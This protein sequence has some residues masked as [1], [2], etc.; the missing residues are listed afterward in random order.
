V[1]ALD[2]RAFEQRLDAYGVERS[3]EA[4]AVRVR[5]KETSER[6]AIVARYAD[7]FTHKQ[8]EA[9]RGAEDAAGDD[10]RE[11]VASRPSTPRSTGSSARPSSSPR[12]SCSST[13]SG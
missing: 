11:S 8:L 12:R 9:L 10:E 6:A 13:T 4:R 3:E 7:L 5:E 1:T 2:V